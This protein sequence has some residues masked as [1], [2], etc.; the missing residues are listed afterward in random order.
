MQLRFTRSWTYQG[1]NTE[2]AER[3]EKEMGKLQC[4]CGRIVY[5]AACPKCDEGKAST[6][7][8]QKKSEGKKAGQGLPVRQPGQRSSSKKIGTGIGW[9]GG[10]I[11]Q[12]TG[13]VVRSFSG[14]GYM[15]E[16][17]DF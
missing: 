16:R 2:N 11:G 3:S 9:P 4:E 6:A 15:R 13:A 17:E 10:N 7:E 12:R 1:Q 8:T 14:N 5:G